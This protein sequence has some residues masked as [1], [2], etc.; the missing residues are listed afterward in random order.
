MS[1]IKRLVTAATFVS[2][3][4]F[5]FVPLEARE[6]MIT[7]VLAAQVERYNKAPKDKGAAAFVDAILPDAS[8]QEKAD[9]RQ[10]VTGIPQ[11]PTMKVEG[12]N[13][14]LIG[15]GADLV[16]LELLNLDGTA[17]VNGKNFKYIHSKGF[18]KNYAELK[19]LLETKKVSFWQHVIPEA[20]ASALLAVGIIATVAIF[21]TAFFAGRNSRL[22]AELATAKGNTVTVTGTATATATA[23]GTTTTTVTGTATETGTVVS[24]EL[25]AP[26]GAAPENGVSTEQ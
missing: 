19:T 9:F 12:P 20:H 4:F 13:K 23:T 21:A 7:Q 16:T 11:F 26:D 3:G 1:A 22:K 2:F 18:K 6:Q 5:A 17:K 15:K 14:V 25:G 24:H 8:I 10:L